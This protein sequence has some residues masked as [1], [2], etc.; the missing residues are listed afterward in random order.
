MRKTWRNLIR[1][2]RMIDYCILLES[3]EH[4]RVILELKNEFLVGSWLICQHLPCL[5]NFRYMPRGSVEIWMKYILYWFIEG[6]THIWL[7]LQS[8]EIGCSSS[9]S[10]TT[11]Q[12]CTTSGKKSLILHANQAIRRKLEGTNCKTKKS[13]TESWRMTQMYDFE[14]IKLSELYV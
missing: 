11:F 3:C 13:P 7:G 12:A 4:N 6:E 10:T 9:S 8:T 1:L 14:V 2:A 5:V